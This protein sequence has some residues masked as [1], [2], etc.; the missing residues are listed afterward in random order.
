MVLLRFLYINIFAFLL[1]GL[2]VIVFIMPREI[3]IIT[4]KTIF[5]ILPLI[6]GIG[7]LSQW[8]G[9]NKKLK[10]IVARN[11]K[12]IRLDTFERLKE[13]PCGWVVADLALRELRKTEN[14]KSFSKTDWKKIKRM[15]IGGHTGQQTPLFACAGHR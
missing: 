6:G 1:I 10:I 5:A 12:G 4:I 3:F 11:M 13:T 8:K 2:S 7:I 14:Y 15:V 9:K